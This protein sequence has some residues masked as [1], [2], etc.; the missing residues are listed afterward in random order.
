MYYIISNEKQRFF[1]DINY[2]WFIFSKNF[3]K[4]IYV[5]VIRDTSYSKTLFLLL[6]DFLLKNMTCFWIVHTYYLRY[7]K[8]YQSEQLRYYIALSGNIWNNAVYSLVELSI[9]SP[10]LNLLLCSIYFLYN[11]THFPLNI[12]CFWWL[13]NNNF[14]V[15]FC[16]TK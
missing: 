11:T 4:N 5:I 16:Q 2:I 15:R 13:S 6:T 3:I 12:K 9:Q 10:Y 1:K 14:F 8:A 7:N